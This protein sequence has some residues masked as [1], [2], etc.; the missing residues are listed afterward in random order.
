M[1]AMKQALIFLTGC[2]MISAQGLQRADNSGE[3]GPFSAW[4]TKSLHPLTS[5]SGHLEL[6]PLKQM[7]GKARIVA[8]S[9]AGHMNA[10]PLL[11]RNRLLEYLVE[12]MGFTAIAIESGFTE[13][14][15]V[16][17]YVLGAPGDIKSV[18]K[19]GLGWTF[20]QL[21]QNEAL[22]AW[23]REYNASPKHPRKVRFYGFDVPGSP[24]NPQANRGLK[25]AIEAALDYLAIVDS[26]AAAEFRRRTEPLLPFL[27]VRA[28]D[29]SVRLYAQLPPAER[30][31]LTATVADMVALFERRA[32]D[33]TVA[34]SA[35]A[36]WWAYHNAIG[37]RQADNWLR[38]N[39]DRKP[40]DSASFGQHEVRD[41]A[42]ADNLRWIA[43]KEGPQGKVL[44]FASSFHIATA[45][46]L[47]VVAGEPGP[48]DPVGRYL[49][50]EMGEGLVNIGNFFGGGSL[51]C[52]GW[53]EKVEIPDSGIEKVFG[54]LTK[55]DFLL[56]LRSAP[57]AIKNWLDQPKMIWHL[58]DNLLI[59]IAQAFDIVYFTH[60]V[61]PA[62]PR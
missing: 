17:D 27:N 36:Y 7:I 48:G 23:L 55:S 15:V 24:G 34:S 11:F 26:P 28:T 47:P 43:E 10:E 44:V 49:R 30:D 8:L 58:P 56:D 52:A 46:Y 25:T 6:S 1:C 35:E 31:R 41:R 51:G 42:M 53:E 37:A 33:Y 40:N 4:A 16:H 60:N 3:S 29:S 5:D 19:M 45:R 9:E 62:C 21:P 57:S 14:Q 61:T 38:Q 20:D 22:I 50:E 2:V 32:T 54:S 59:P 18:T 13:A 39:P 12:E